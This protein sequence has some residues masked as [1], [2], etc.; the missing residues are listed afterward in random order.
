MNY[1][2]C[3]LQPRKSLAVRDSDD[4]LSRNNYTLNEG[5]R[6]FP[7]LLNGSVLCQSVF[8]RKWGAVQGLLRG[9]YLSFDLLPPM[10]LPPASKI[11]LEPCVW[12]HA[13]CF[14]EFG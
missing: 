12:L 10:E 3:E 5:L 13:Q 6:C 14:K 11:F 7:C 4:I 1:V 2:H 9:G 8:L